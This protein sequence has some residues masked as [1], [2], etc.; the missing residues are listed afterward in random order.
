MNSS[1]SKGLYIYNDDN[2]EAAFDEAYKLSLE[3]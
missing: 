2:H 1:N 3:D